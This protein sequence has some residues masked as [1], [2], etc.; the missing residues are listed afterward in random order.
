MV[1]GT[2]SYLY[3]KK[4]ININYQNNLFTNIRGHFCFKL[5]PGFVLSLLILTT[6]QIYCQQKWIPFSTK[7]IICNQVTGEQIRQ[8]NS[9]NQ[10][11][12]LLSSGSG[13]VSFTVHV[14]GMNENEKNVGSASYQEIFI[15]DCGVTTSVGS[16]QL[17][18]ITKLIA[19]PDC[20]GVTISIS[21]SNESCLSNYYIIPAPAYTDN[22]NRGGGQSQ[23]KYFK[24]NR[25][26]YSND[27]F[28]PGKYGEIIETGYVRSQKVARIAIYPV[29]FNPSKKTIRVCADLSITLNFINPKSPVNKELG[30][31]R[32]I[33][34]SAALNYEPGGISAS[35]K[36]LN[37][38]QNNH[39]GKI[40]S[41]S[42]ISGSVTRV[43][44]VNLLIGVNAIPVD[45][46]IITHSSL[47]NSS[48]LTKLADYR[49]INNGFDVAIVQVDSTI[50]NV[51]TGRPHY[52]SIRDFIADVYLRGKANHT[53]DG[54][55]GYIVLVGDAYTAPPAQE[56]M[57][58]AA[59]PS[60]YSTYEQAGDYYYSC[61]GG[62]KDDLQDLIYGR[63]SVETEDELSN[64]VNK[65]IAYESSPTANW[66]NNVC[67]MT[68]SPWFFDDDANCDDYFYQMTHILSRSN[69]ISY[70]WRGFTADT[71]SAWG[72]LYFQN[73][74]TDQISILNVPN[75]INEIWYQRFTGWRWYI[76]TIDSSAYQ[77]MPGGEYADST[78]NCGASEFDDWLYNKLNSGQRIFIYEGHSGH[79]CLG[80]GEGLGRTIFRVDQLGNKLR[81]YGMYPFIIA[82]GCETG[83]FD[84]IT[85]DDMGSIDCLAEKTVKMQNAG[86]IGFLGSTRESTPSAF[87]SVDSDVLQ[88]FYV[89][90]SH[91]MGEAVMESKLLLNSTFRRQ[92]NLYGD[93]AINLWNNN[94]I[95][96]NIENN[97]I[98]SANEF[99]L[100][101][102]YPNPFNPTTMIN[103][104][105]ESAG[106]VTLKVFDA[107]GREIKTLVSENKN[108]GSY[109]VLFNGSKYA[110]GVYYYQLK[111]NLLSN[112]SYSGGCFVSTKKMIL[113]K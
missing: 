27:S 33:M 17:P 104:N 89:D 23:M 52:Q 49:E 86:A 39:L 97:K 64:V 66:Q 28:Y 110:S 90:S 19:I 48:S 102:N 7:E 58:P 8:V 10:N 80:A 22:K 40:S 1:T 63:I 11:T 82:N 5:L 60:Y 94:N 65:T 44:N 84:A 26:V 41:T 105:L 107:L 57:V 113:I 78:N 62:D 67:F 98:T 16:P 68:Y 95:A 13:G 30:I 55:L 106:Y 43:T 112:G 100:N 25:S 42:S 38:L 103:Y 76:P 12:T 99:A 111:I 24:E 37:I 69:Y 3:F 72:R 21:P 36:K 15:P 35:S 93:P 108:Q 59:Y 56:E 14:D 61:T 50:Y 29:Q 73:H 2:I 85:P 87:N 74:S 77:I 51:Y 83:E 47:F 96:A 9:H 53:G 4:I 81:N 70:A 109:T 79:G 31:F 75:D 92:Y 20:D 32:N 88:A 101:N 18:I 45:Y 34:H 54:R 6:A 71:A 91:I 46:L